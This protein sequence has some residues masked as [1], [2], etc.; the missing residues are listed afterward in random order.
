MIKITI[1]NNGVMKEITIPETTVHIVEDADKA[2]LFAE[3]LGA[4]VKDIKTHCTDV[5][6]NNGGS[7]HFNVVGESKSKKINWDAIVEE[8]GVSKDV[9]EKWTSTISRKA[10][11]KVKKTLNFF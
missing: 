9:I 6:V 5:V 8:V 4:F 3:W 11:I 2:L 10:Y 7:E 1:N